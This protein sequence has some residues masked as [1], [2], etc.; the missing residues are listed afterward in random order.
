MATRVQS[1]LERIERIL[2]RYENFTI[3]RKLEVGYLSVILACEDNLNNSIQVL[4][5]FYVNM[6]K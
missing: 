5:Q 3:K 6:T 4:S 2:V 1:R